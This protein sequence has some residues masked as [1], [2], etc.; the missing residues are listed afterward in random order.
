MKKNTLAVLATAVLAA[1]VMAGCSNNKQAEASA[2][3]TTAEPATEATTEAPKD[4]EAEFV[5]VG[6]DGAGIIAAIQA[7]NEGADPSKVIIVEKSGKIASD[8]AAMGDKMNATNTDEQFD[9]EIE[10]TFEAYLAD[11][12]K[13]GGEKNSEELA[14]FVA[15]SS[16]TALTWLRD[17]DIEVEGV[18]KESGSSFARS[19]AATGDKKLSEALTELLIKEAEALKIKVMTDTTVE[20]IL[21][22]KEGA[23]AGLKVKNADGEETINCISML[24]TDPAALTLLKEVPVVYTKDAD[25]KENGIVVNNCAEVLTDAEDSVPGLYAAGPI[26]DAAVYGDEALTGN[27]ITSTILFGL[28]AGTEMN[29][30]TA[31]HK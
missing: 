12:K 30:Y 6:G 11:I 19:Y 2:P 18:T 31:D 29:I 21:F 8:V 16:E 4:M 3:A 5:A 14:E 17:S 20:E 27:Q 13:A 10:D 25:G 26:I 9:Q 23:V 24:I 15:E 1:S 28:T 22:D 7:V